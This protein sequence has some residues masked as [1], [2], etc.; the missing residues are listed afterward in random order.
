MIRIAT[1]SVVLFVAAG[2]CR[3][4]PFDLIVPSEVQIRTQ[5]GVGGAGSPW[6]WIVSTSAPLT[7]DQ[8]D[9][10]AFS[11]ATD[12]PAVVVT[13]TFNPGAWTP[14]QPGDVAGLDV[15]P[16]TDPL[17]VFLD[18]AESVNPLSENF[19][20]WQIDFPA[21]FV[22]T[23]NLHTIADIGGWRAAYDT[24]LHFGPS[25]GSDADPLVIVEAQRVSAVPESSS[26][27]LILASVVS[28]L[29]IHRG[30]RLTSRCR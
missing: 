1:C 8:L 21:E 28:T 10:N 14:M 22:G 27:R 5:P 12:H 3:S 20:R 19:W 24:V 17:R 16:F 23:V 18:P 6:G 25:F 26:C 7:F 9:S 11:L 29:I 30:G 4:A 2:V 15:S 13:T